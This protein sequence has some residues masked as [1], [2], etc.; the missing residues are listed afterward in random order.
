MAGSKLV[1]EVTR[2]G[3]LA[4]PARSGVNLDCLFGRSTRVV[5]N[6]TSRVRRK[7]C[8]DASRLL[9]NCAKGTRGPG[10]RRSPVYRAPLWRPTLGRQPP[11]E[12]TPSELMRKLLCPDPPDKASS[13]ALQRPS[14][15]ASPFS[16]SEELRKRLSV[17][18]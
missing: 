15:Y 9:R 7:C 14:L 16:F 12:H 11:L 3:L 5:R 2:Q 8:A 13:P 17:P 10:S 6:R 4:R 1:I 18:G